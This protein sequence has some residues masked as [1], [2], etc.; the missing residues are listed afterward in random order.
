MLQRELRDTS[1]FQLRS[2]NVVPCTYV[3]A[4]L[5]PSP[6]P[7]PQLSSLAVRITHIRTASN[8]SCG[9][10]L[11]TRLRIHMRIIRYPRPPPTTFWRVLRMRLAKLNLAKILPKYKG[12]AIGENFIPRIFGRILST[13]NDIV[14][15][16]VYLD[17]L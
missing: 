2:W 12:R 4:S 15:Y 1:D 8:D 16:I 5:I 9:G 14:S 17:L 11:G 13:M 3:Y 6:R 7:P 10:G